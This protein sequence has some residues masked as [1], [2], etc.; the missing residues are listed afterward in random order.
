MEDSRDSPVRTARQYFQPLLVNWQG[1]NSST[2]MHRKIILLV[3]FSVIMVPGWS[4]V[5][6]L[7]LLVG[8]GPA[9]SVI[10]SAAPSYSE[11]V[12]YLHRGDLKPNSAVV[13]L[14]ADVTPFRQKKLL[15]QTGLAYS[16][17]TKGNVFKRDVYPINGTSTR[18]VSFWQEYSWVSVPVHLGY[19]FSFRHVSPFVFGGIGANYLLP[20]NLIRE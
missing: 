16:A 20:K 2:A 13:G 14:L 1:R 8:L 10:T 9:H 15:L 4:Q 18:L 5:K 11:A 12:S 7:R 3:A 19:S 6:S 17:F